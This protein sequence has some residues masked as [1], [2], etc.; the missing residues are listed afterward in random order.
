MRGGL[1]AALFL[2]IAAPA[3]AD[4][5]GG[6]GPAG[7]AGGGGAFAPSGGAGGGAAYNPHPPKKKARFVLKTFTVGTGRFYELGTPARVIWRIDS[8]ARTVHAKLD[9]RRAGRRLRLID[10][11]R[12]STGRRQ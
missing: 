10:L 5:G 2:A 7:G 3:A 11:G 9:V 4:S 8:R 12:H 6:L 1:A